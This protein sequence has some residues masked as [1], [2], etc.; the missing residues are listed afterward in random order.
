MLPKNCGSSV[1]VQKMLGLQK[2]C[3]L[4]NKIILLTTYVVAEILVRS[5]SFVVKKDTKGN[6]SKCRKNH[7]AQKNICI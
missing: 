1:L 3:S 2:N 4:N 7:R 6:T 5:N